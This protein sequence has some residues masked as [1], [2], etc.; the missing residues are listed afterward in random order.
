MEKELISCQRTKIHHFALIAGIFWWFCLVG[1]AFVGVFCLFGFVV[2]LFVWVLVGFLFGSF[3]LLVGLV[4]F[5]ARE[6]SGSKGGCVELIK[7]LT[8]R[9]FSS[10]I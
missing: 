4:G 2:G 8:L 10:V 7:I 9:R 5:L 1:F 6:M 3:F